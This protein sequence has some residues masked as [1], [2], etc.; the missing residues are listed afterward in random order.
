MGDIVDV[1][2]KMWEVLTTFSKES[3]KAAT[4]KVKELGIDPKKADVPL[5][6]SLIN[7]EAATRILS[8]AITQKKLTQIPLTLQRDLLTKVESISKHLVALVGGA[9]EVINLVASINS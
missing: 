7:L 3:F 6:E 1:G 4:N 8:D 9:D 2:A 5:D